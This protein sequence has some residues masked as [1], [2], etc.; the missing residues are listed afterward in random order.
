[1]TRVLSFGNSVLDTFSVKVGSCVPVGPCPLPTTPMLPRLPPAAKAT[2]ESYMLLNSEK[3]RSMG[4][5]IMRPLVLMLGGAGCG[6]VVR[7]LSGVLSL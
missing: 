1:M 2:E 3:E 4:G 5:Q 6:A 7:A